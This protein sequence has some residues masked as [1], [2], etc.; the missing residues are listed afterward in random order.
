M[1][2]R[3][4]LVGTVMKLCGGDVG[5]PLASVLEG[6]VGT[7]GGL[8]NTTTTICGA[9]SIAVCSIIFV[10]RPLATNISVLMHT[11]SKTSTKGSAAAVGAITQLLNALRTAI[12]Y[13]DITKDS[14]LSKGRLARDQI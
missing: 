1:A 11:A 3:G 7:V 6:L 13:K 8:K 5:R 2:V 12:E 9:A 10:C 4:E 14:N